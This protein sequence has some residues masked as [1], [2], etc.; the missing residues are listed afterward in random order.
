MRC[1]IVGNEI[2]RAATRE[3]GIANTA[4]KIENA[5]GH[6]TAPVRNVVDKTRHNARA[7]PSLVDFVT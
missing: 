2:S 5:C 7:M 1:A 4:N 3:N 6:L